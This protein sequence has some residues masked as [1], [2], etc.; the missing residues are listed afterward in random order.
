MKKCPKCKTPNPLGLGECGNCGVIFADIRSD[1]QQEVARPCP[2]NDH[3]DICG[4]VGSL[5][6]A[7]NGSGPWYCPEHYWQLKG[8]DISQPALTVPRLS[9]RDRWYAERGLTYEPPKKNPALQI[10]GRMREPGEDDEGIA[11]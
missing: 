4:K 9:Y 6:N 10:V 3:G 8:R 11:A 7:T 2:W 1:G 5:S